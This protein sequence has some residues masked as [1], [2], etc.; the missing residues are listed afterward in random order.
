MKLDKATRDKLV[1]LIDEWE[2]QAVR[3]LPLIE[4]LRERLKD[5]PTEPKDAKK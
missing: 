2:A 5:E 3:N 4:F 1:A